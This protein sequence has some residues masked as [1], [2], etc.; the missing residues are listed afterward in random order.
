DYRVKELSRVTKEKEK[1]GLSNKDKGKK[2]MI[3]FC[4]PNP[5]K[6]FHI[7]HLYSNIVGESLAKLFESQ[8]ATVKRA[9]YQGDV[10]M[11]VAKAIW[12]LQ[13]IDFKKLEKES[14]AKRIKVLGEAY[15]KGDKAFEKS[16]KAKKEITELNAKVFALD[17][18]V[19]NIYEKGRK[20]S[21]EYFETMYKRLGMKFDYY[22]FER[23]AGEVGLKIVKEGLK[24]GIFKESKGAVVFLGEKYGLHSRVFINSQGLPT[25]EA[26]ELGLAPTKYKDFKYD[27]SVIVTGNEIIEYFKVLI[28]A[29]K[30]VNPELGEKTVHLSHG[31]IRLQEGKMSSRKGNIIKGGELLDETKKR[32]A[33]L[34]ADEKTAEIVALGAVKY[35]L[36][37]V[38]LGRDIIFD[39]EKSLSTEGDSGPY[40]QYTYARCKSILRK[41]QFPISNFQNTYK[42][43]KKEEL[44]ILR[45]IYKFP[46]VVQE[47]AEKYAP[48]IICNY[49]FDVAQAYN[50]FYNTTPVLGADTKEAR[51]FR[52][53]LTASTAQL[54]QNSLHLLGIQTLEKM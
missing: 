15:A 23:D 31:M 38:S 39:F 17:K 19:K 24:K 53:L 5:F 10:G 51:D 44:G 45:L 36:L 37:R 13:N 7:G 30:E 8:G 46:E 50:H 47:A 54:I 22:Y 11:H 42:D 26:K 41:S 34:N 9:N 29:L 18:D 14:L 6:E 43:F 32:V 4:D 48:N 35:S 28:A 3:E 40:L 12:G 21:L 20:W 2:V 25:Y 1:Y 33:K 52:L 49:V 27:L 16:E